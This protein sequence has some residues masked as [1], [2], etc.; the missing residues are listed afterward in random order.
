MLEPIRPNVL[1]MHAYVPGKPISEVKRELG[2]E[3]VVKLAS[4]ENPFGPSPKA[5]AAVEQTARQMH[6]YPDGA[7]RDLREA[8]AK[9]F[10]IPYE[11]VMVGNGSDELIHILGLLF[12]DGPGDEM[13]MGD[14]GFSRYDA[15]AHLAN[16]KLVKVPVD[17]DFRHDLPAM[18]AAVTPNTKL[19]YLANPNNPTGTVMTTAEIEG[20]LDT[21]PENVPVVLDEAYHDF[22]APYT[23]LPNSRD[24][25]LQG[26]NVIGLRTFSKAY[27]LAGIRIGFG[28][29]SP[30]VMDAYHRAREPF[31]V[32]ILAQSAAIAALGDDEHLQ[33]TVTNNR[34]GL[35]RLRRIFESIGAR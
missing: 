24:L 25:V 32:N 9:K 5:V 15:S 2:L 3:R 22:A 16:A 26:R 30:R 27:G 8:L 31:N 4:N 20:F 28:F 35:D 21:I 13:M 34:E 7:S 1:E 29:A 23:D 17:S 14:P 10:D 6:L 11:Q 33:K 12:L 18:A 19:I